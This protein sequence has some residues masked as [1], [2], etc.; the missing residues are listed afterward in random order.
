M[1]REV[2]G[3]PPQ[4]HCW[5]RTDQGYNSIKK[6]WVCKLIHGHGSCRCAGAAGTHTFARKGTYGYCVLPIALSLLAGALTAHVASIHHKLT[7]AE[8]DLHIGRLVTSL[9]VCRA[10]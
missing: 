1:A 4:A 10:T 7:T 3:R 9:Q 6:N 8:L 2:V 5:K